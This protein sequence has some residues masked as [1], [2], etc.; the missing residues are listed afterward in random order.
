MRWLVSDLMPLGISLIG[1]TN[2]EG[3]FLINK[4]PNDFDLNEEEIMRIGSLH[5]MRRLDAN[6][7]TLKL[8]DLNVCSFFSGLITAQ[9]Y[10]APNFVISLFLEKHEDPKAYT[11]I[12]PL[13]S[14]IVLS[15]FHKTV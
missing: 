14:K 7:I 15:E 11:K 1:W 12:L 4:Y 3:F 6:V 10:I 5:R 2:K 9:Y 8:K 13:G